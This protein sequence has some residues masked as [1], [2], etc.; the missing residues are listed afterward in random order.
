MKGKRMLGTYTAFM[1]VRKKGVEKEEISL[2][3][4]KML[5]WIAWSLLIITSSPHAL[6]N[7]EMNNSQVFPVAQNFPRTIDP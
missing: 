4:I 7:F 5:E 6:L 2:F 3:L 1:V